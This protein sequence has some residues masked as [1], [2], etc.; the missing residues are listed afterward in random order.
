M[1]WLEATRG[2]GRRPRPRAHP[3]HHRSARHR[4]RQGRRAR[5][6]DWMLDA[7]APHDRR[8]RA[9]RRLDD[10]HLHQLPDDPGADAR[11]ARRLRRHRRRHLFELGV[12]RALEFRGRPVGA[13]RRPHRPHAALRLSSRCAA[14]GD[15]ALARR[16]DA[17]DAQRLG[18]ARRRHRQARRQLL[19]GAGGRGHRGR[20]RLRRAQALRR[21][22]GELRLDRAVPPRRHHA[23][24]ARGS[25]T[26][27]ASGCR[28][29][30]IGARRRRGA[31]ARLCSRPTRST[32]SSSRRRS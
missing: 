17:D 18:R 29:H 2:R 3:D 5:P 21:G 31:A 16:L 4:F 28:A 9:A 32:S 8:V 24:G 15:A 14:A 7:R 23:G 11:R 19:G 10:R 13:L 30:R 22:D 12:R 20:A 1:R 27:A 26:S 25:P 6:G